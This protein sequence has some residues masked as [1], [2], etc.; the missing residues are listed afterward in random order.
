MINIHKQSR[1]KE[2]TKNKITQLKVR[3]YI[4]SGDA[5]LDCLTA[6]G[7]PWNG[8]C[9]AYTSKTGETCCMCNQ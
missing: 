4:Q 9:S 6:K 5:C 2:G 1:G 7:C 3:T 8:G